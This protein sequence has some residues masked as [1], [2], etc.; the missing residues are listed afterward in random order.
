M[1]RSRLPLKRPE[2][3]RDDDANEETHARR[4][5]SDARGSAMSEF[6]PALDVVLAH[7]GGLS[8]HPAD[9]GGLTN[10]GI[11]LATFRDYRGPQATG[12]ELRH[13][14]RGDAAKIYGDLWWN[15]YGYGRIADQRCATKL[16]DCS[17]NMGAKR[18]HVLAQQATNALGVA[19]AVDGI[20]GE[21]SIAG[22]N[23]CDPDQWLNAM[24]VFRGGWMKRAAWPLAADSLRDQGVA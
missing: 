6:G 19:L 22:I 2:R 9:P 23:A 15:R 13:L 12:D 3:D 1:R 4:L 14:T 7:E 20:L 8:D 11:T 24:A 18:A 21:Q 16:F 17:V 5:Y 10:M